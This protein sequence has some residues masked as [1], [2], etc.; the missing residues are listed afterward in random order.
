LF[1]SSL[2]RGECLLI[3]GGL[4]LELRLALCTGLIRWGG[5]TCAEFFLLL[6]PL[7]GVYITQ[8]ALFFEFLSESDG[9]IK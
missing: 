8:F 4:G 1:D 9:D 5:S 6:K 7:L 2:A 3:G